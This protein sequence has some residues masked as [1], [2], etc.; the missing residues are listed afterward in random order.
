M[1][2]EISDTFRLMPNDTTTMTKEN[3][4]NSCAGRVRRKISEARKWA[5]ETATGPAADTP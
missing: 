1:G 4:P 2:T 3:S 5:P